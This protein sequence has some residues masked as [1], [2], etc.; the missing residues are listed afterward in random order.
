MNTTIVT[1]F[2]DIGRG[3][4]SGE[5]NGATIPSFI[6]R[7]T[8]TY[9]ERFERLTKIANPIICYTES[10]HFDKIKAMREDIELI[11]ID[12]LFEDH[13]PVLELVKK[14][15][16]NQ[17]FI[18]LLRHPSSPEYWSPEYVIINFM[19]SFFVTHAFQQGLIK[20][21]NAAWID[22]GYCR[23]V[24]FNDSFEW[25]YNT[26]DKI[27]LFYIKEPDDTP[28]FS[29]VRSGEV[30]IQ[31]CHVVAPSDMWS[32]LKAYMIQAMNQLIGTGLIDDDQTMLLM[33]YRMGPENFKLNYVDPSNWFVVFERS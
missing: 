10:K 3:D 13:H 28:I 18:S 4:W 24:L 8:N 23:E 22:F 7:D 16:T 17:E 31:G 26:E 12:K 15:Q 6:K 25:S 9:F 19:K 5:A 1:A 14:I 29:I 27:N 21:K 32:T 20:T 11:S 30:Y 2:V 33:S